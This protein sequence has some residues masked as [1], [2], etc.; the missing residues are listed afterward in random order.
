MDNNKQ[1]TAF[2][3]EARCVE[4]NLREGKEHEF[5]YELFNLVYNWYIKE[6]EKPLEKQN[7]IYENLLKTML[8]IT[9]EDIDGASAGEKIRST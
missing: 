2:E 3:Y 5:P 1:E 4:R 6:R 9:P 8:K 7:K